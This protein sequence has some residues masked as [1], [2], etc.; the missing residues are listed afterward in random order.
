MGHLELG[1]VAR[2]H[3]Y[4]LGSGYRSVFWGSE[5][6]LRVSINSLGFV[7]TGLFAAPAMQSSLAS[8]WSSA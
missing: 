5:A 6:C 1:Q 2:A 3:T 8:R 7:G 4:P